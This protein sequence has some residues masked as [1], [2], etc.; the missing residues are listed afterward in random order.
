MAT[1]KLSL[2]PSTT[3][4]WAARL[5]ALTMASAAIAALL[6][7]LPLI[8]N[9]YLPFEDLPSHIARRYILSGADPA[10]AA[11]YQLRGGLATNSAVDIIWHI[12]TWLSPVTAENVISFSHWTM[13]FSMLGLV[14]S[15]MIL[16]RVLHGRWS[17]WSLLSGLLIY[18]GNVIWGFENYV[19]TLPLGIAAFALW[20]AS[21]T[22]APWA[23]LCLTAATVV[24]LYLGHIFVLLAYAILVFGYE[25]GR[26][27]QSKGDGLKLDLKSANWL[28][29]AIVAAAC[30]TY[31]LASIVGPKPSYGSTTDFGS[32]PMHLAAFLTPF[33]AVNLPES[34]MRP[35]IAQSVF[36]L[37]GILVLLLLDGRFGIKIQRVTAMKWPLRLLALVAL[38]MPVQLYGVYYVHIR[39][40]VLLFALLIAASDMKI[41]GRRAP[42]ISILLII[43]LLSTIAIRASIMDRAARAYS[44]QIQDIQTLADALNAETPVGA[45][46]LPV[47]GETSPP[48]TTFQSHSAAYLAPFSDAFVPTLFVAGSHRFALIPS[49]EHLSAPQPNPLPTELLA[50]TMR[51]WNPAYEEPW[52][53]AYNWDKNFT[54]ML[55]IGSVPENFAQE[56]DL[57][58]ISTANNATLFAIK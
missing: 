51:S 7:M 26:L 13:G 35:L 39:F 48:F 23:R 40:P 30:F 10:L 46:V 18:N 34:L 11:Y 58:K 8:W 41:E 25:G 19:V 47:L 29:L 14:G 15:V 36:L 28:G 5:P 38:L 6:I 3:G 1:N 2:Q 27:W 20:I 54:H 21:R 57:R 32:I 52:R 42:A 17:P 49:L 4:R 31:V 43:A 22:A 9:A 16:H 33:G 37:C 12:R 45:K 50:E 53:Y 44:G 24:I 56:F 55:V